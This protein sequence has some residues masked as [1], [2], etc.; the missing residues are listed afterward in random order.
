MPQ[1]SDD[2]FRDLP[3][4]DRRYDTPVADQLVFSVFPNGVKAWV[5]VY[6]CDD[7]VRRRTIGL[8]PETGYEAALAALD[9]SR[10]IAAVDALETRRRPRPPGRGPRLLLVVLIAALLAS[11][12]TYLLMARGQDDPEAVPPGTPLQ[13]SMSPG[14]VAETTDRRGPPP[15]PATG[16]AI[17]VGRESPAVPEAASAPP[18]HP[19]E[20]SAASPPGDRPGAESA[21]EM[22]GSPVARNPGAA[23]PP[24]PDPAVTPAGPA[25]GPAPAEAPGQ[26]VTSG[27][28][29]RSGPAADAHSGTPEVTADADADESPATGDVR[30]SRSALAMNIR[31]R[32]PVDPISDELSVAPD[33]TVTVYFFTELR[34]TPGE[35]V[36]HRWELDGNTVAEIPFKIGNGSRWRVYSSKAIGPDDQGRWRAV[37]VDG[38]GREIDALKFN[39]RTESP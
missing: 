2:Y 3:P 23:E 13:S 19:S 5:H 12:G 30:V 7:F 33:Q 31:D 27:E 4:R 36:K 14:S 22:A 24:V 26:R 34:G 15:G 39:A 37:V 28:T 29:P 32:E 38:A 18:S 16:P 6:P 35:T 17:P 8:F 25:Q 10:R 1:F 11:L 21:P 20:P 9:H